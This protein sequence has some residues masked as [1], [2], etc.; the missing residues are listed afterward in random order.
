[1]ID[2]T[3]SYV[4]ADAIV[5]TDPRRLASS[6]QLPH[7]AFVVR[8]RIDSAD[9]KAKAKDFHPGPGMPADVFIKTQQR[10]FADY[11]LKPLRDSMTHAFRE[12]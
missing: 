10:T 6:A 2:A 5:E 7:G 3:V 1:M 9:L 11:I 4:S 12:T 8:V